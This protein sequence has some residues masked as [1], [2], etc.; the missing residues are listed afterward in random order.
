[1]RDETEGL[2]A[3]LG[4]LSEALRARA[5]TAEDPA[6]L[7]STASTGTSRDELPAALALAARAAEE[8]GHAAADLDEA[9]SALRAYLEHVY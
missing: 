2:I 8:S 1:M 5:A 4:G 3:S 7:L 9:A 6:A